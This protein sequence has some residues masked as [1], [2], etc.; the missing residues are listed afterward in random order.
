MK[1]YSNFIDKIEELKNDINDKI[2]DFLKNSQELKEFIEFRK[3]NFYNYSIRNNILIYKQDKT[4]TMVAG[5]QKW[6]E[7]GYNI[8]KGARAIKILVPLFRKEEIDGEEKEKIYG[9]IY[10]NVFDIKHTI[11]TENAVEIPTIDT[12][13][14][15]GKSK[16]GI[17]KLFNKSKEI[18]EQYLPVKIKEEL[19]DRTS[20]GM[21]DGKIITL[22][23]D[24]FVAMSGTLM[25]EFTHYLNHFDKE[26]RSRNQE[27]VEA[28]LGAMLYGSYFNLD[29]SGKYKYIALWKN[30]NVRLDEA[31]DVALSS[32]EQFLYGVG[33]DKKGLIDLLKEEK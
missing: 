13:M 3:K 7:M 26:K 29:I 15:E 32:F 12:R 10:A 4:A 28:E 27:E 19:D 16:Y 8:K 23:K 20:R 14:K 18:V 25:H 11:P 33:E 30:N 2:E 6:K 22:K 24:K 31:F 5:F 9:F 21:T 17:T 1:E